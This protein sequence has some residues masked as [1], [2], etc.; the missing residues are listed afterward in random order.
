VQ[1]MKEKQVGKVLRDPNGSISIWWQS[2][3]T[4]FHLP[5]SFV[6]ASNSCNYVQG[7]RQSYQPRKQVDYIH[8]T[9]TIPISFSQSHLHHCSRSSAVASPPSLFPLPERKADS[10]FTPCFPPSCGSLPLPAHHFSY[11]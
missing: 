4:A 10:G 5:Y 2:S 3:P 11:V 7:D 1:I 6:L 8:F 9:S